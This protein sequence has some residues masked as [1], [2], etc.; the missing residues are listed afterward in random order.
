MKNKQK[1]LKN[2]QKRFDQKNNVELILIVVFWLVLLKRSPVDSDLESISVF[3]VI[4][5]V[6][7]FRGFSGFCASSPTGRENPPVLLILGALLQSFF[8]KGQNLWQVASFSM[9]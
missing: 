6:Q 8:A 9:S 2:G 4:D 7:G 5:E 3:V 1:S